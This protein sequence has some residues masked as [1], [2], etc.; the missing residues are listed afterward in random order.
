MIARDKMSKNLRPYTRSES[1]ELRKITSSDIN[2]EIIAT[3]ILTK[4]RNPSPVILWYNPKMVTLAEPHIK[5][6]ISEIDMYEKTKS[7]LYQAIEDLEQTHQQFLKDSEEKI[8]SVL[9][10]GHNF[11][12]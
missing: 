8:K 7:D 10:K 2:E 1:G 6:R 11:I 4:D 5:S 9:E 12:L 3:F